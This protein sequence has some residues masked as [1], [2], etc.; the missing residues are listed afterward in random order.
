M[1]NG[2]PPAR[3]SDD[4]AQGKMAHI[5]EAYVQHWTEIG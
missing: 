2:G 4:L 5:G 1:L 3:F